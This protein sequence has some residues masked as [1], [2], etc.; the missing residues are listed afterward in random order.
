MSHLAVD[1]SVTL[2]EDRPGMLARAIRAIGTA[3]VNIDGYAE[4]GGVVRVLTTDIRRTRDALEGEGFKVLGEQQVCV[5]EVP[6]RPGAAG[7]IFQRIADAGINVSFSYLATRNR[8]VI[9]AASLGR[10]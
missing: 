3:G 10:S 2:P 9:G 7:E 4:M 5:V 8:L 6:D 1:L